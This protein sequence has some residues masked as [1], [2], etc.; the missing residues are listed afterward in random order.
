VLRQPSSHPESTPYELKVPLLGSIIGSMSLTSKEVGLTRFPLEDRPPVMIPF[1]TFRIMV[2]C[3][4]IIHAPR[5]LESTNRHADRPYTER[6][7]APRHAQ[8]CRSI[9]DGN[10]NVTGGDWRNSLAGISGRLCD[11]VLSL[12]NPAPHHASRIDSRGRGMFI[13]PLIGTGAAAVLVA[14]ILRHWDAWPFCMVALIFVSDF[15]TL[16]LLEAPGADESD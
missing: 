1:S 5:R 7:E 3:G 9:W 2:G 11:A 12:L 10:E 14:S 15:G 4:V 13:F 6:R 16:A 8:F